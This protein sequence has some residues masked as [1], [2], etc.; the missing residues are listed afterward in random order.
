[1]AHSTPT[2]VNAGKPLPSSYRLMSIDVRIEVNRIPSADI[3]LLDGNVLNEYEVSDGAY[4]VPV[5]KI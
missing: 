1:M 4:F 2:I 3:R 5:A